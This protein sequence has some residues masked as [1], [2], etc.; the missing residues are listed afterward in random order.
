MAVYGNVILDYY[1]NY[2]GLLLDSWI[3]LPLYD[4]SMILDDY[5]SIANVT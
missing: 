4:F 5:C 2:T 3:M 1:L